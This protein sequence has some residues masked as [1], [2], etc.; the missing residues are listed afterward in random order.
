[1]IV[2][3]WILLFFLSL[4]DI[5]R[6]FVSVVP[7]FKRAS[8]K[9]Q[10]AVLPTVAVSSSK[11]DATITTAAWMLDDMV[12]L[13]SSA[14]RQSRK[15]DDKMISSYRQQEMTMLI[16]DIVLLQSRQDQPGEDDNDNDHDIT[17]PEL[18]KTTPS[19][20]EDPATSLLEPL[21]AI[22]Q[23]LDETILGSYNSEFSMDEM[24]RWVQQ[25]ASLNRELETQI[26]RTLPPP[27]TATLSKREAAAIEVAAVPVEEEDTIAPKHRQQCLTMEEIRSRLENLRILIDPT[28]NQ[29]TR[30]PLVESQTIEATTTTGETRVTIESTGTEIQSDNLQRKTIPFDPSQVFFATV[31]DGTSVGEARSTDDKYPTMVLGTAIESNNENNIT[32]ISNTDNSNDEPDV[33]SAVVGVAALSAAAVTK[34]P[35][36]AA[37]VALG[38]AIRTSIAYAKGR[39]A[40]NYSSIANITDPAIVDG[41]VSP[42]PEE[43]IVI[44]TVQAK[45]TKGQ[46]GA[47]E[48]RSRPRVPYLQPDNLA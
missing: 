20:D 47:T 27:S 30:I 28:G 4:V 34:I 18:Q 19:R 11:E 6:A 38:P 39:M 44:S 23:A 2:K 3:T 1:M 10:V 17:V 7:F 14:A 22:S 21:V 40:A 31:D 32:A 26:Q 16:E 24:D 48:N 37:G 36:I 35:L 13:Y 12:L 25:I 15:D 9:E 33:L 46:D 29:L 41:S 45:K 8:W 43:D 5:I 42:N